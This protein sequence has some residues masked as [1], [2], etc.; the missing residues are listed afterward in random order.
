M[1]FCF[2]NKALLNINISDEIFSSA[3]VACVLRFRGSNKIYLYQK[4]FSRLKS[5]DEYD[6]HFA[7]FYDY[8]FG[9]RNKKKVGYRNSDVSLLVSEYR[10]Y[11]VLRKIL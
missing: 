6:F 3:S 4:L 2:S 1:K 11:T 5:W 7:I 10:T 9:N 8:L